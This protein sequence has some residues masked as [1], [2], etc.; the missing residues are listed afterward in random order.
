[1]NMLRS[2]FT[3]SGPLLKYLAYFSGSYCFLVVFLA[4][5]PSISHHFTNLVTTGAAVVLSNL[6]F[7]ADV[8]L[9]TTHSGYAEIR[10][11]STVYEVNEDCT[12]LSL[13]LLVAAAIVAIPVPLRL[14]ILGVV[15]MGFLAAFVGCMRI[16]ILGCV[17]EYQTDLFDLFHTYLME[18]ATVGIGLW[19]LLFW[20]KFT[21]P[22]RRSTAT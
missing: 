19:M 7:V 22:E 16:V 3:A 20:F 4:T 13:V 21:M 6:G 9:Q 14:R 11:N 17:A 8:Y 10:F 18:V 12:G 2:G 1:M 15:L 5:S